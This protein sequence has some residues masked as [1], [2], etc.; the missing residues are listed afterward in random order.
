MKNHF[1]VPTI[2]F[3]DVLIQTVIWFERF[4]P[5]YYEEIIPSVESV[6]GLMDGSTPS[7]LLETQTVDSILG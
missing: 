5:I 1:D 4:E 6:Q 2:W 3:S 7:H